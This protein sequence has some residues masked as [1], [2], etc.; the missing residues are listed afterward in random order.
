MNIFHNYLFLFIGSLKRKVV[1]ASILM[2]CLYAIVS[3]YHTVSGQ[4][5][6]YYNN[7]RNNLNL[8]VQRL[9][10]IGL[11]EDSRQQS[12]INLE[13][14]N[15]L[16]LKKELKGIAV[17]NNKNQLIDSKIFS[18]PSQMNTRFSFSEI[19]DSSFNYTTIDSFN[20]IQF[21]IRNGEFSIVLLAI[22]PPF[23]VQRDLVSEIEFKFYLFSFLLFSSIIVIISKFLENPIS[24]ITLLLNK[25][26]TSENQSE[27]IPENFL[28]K[29]EKNLIN[30][31]NKI[32]SFY[33]HTINN[34]K[35]HGHD[36]KYHSDD[37]SENLSTFSEA[38]IQQ[39]SATSQ[40]SAAFEELGS[41][42]N[43]IS[44]SSET[45]VSI[46]EKTKISAEEGVI[47]ADETYN[48]IIKIKTNNLTISDKLIELGNRSMMISKIMKDIQEINDQTQ[49]ISFNAMIEAVGAGNAGRRFKVVAEEIK[50]LSEDLER[51]SKSIKSTLNE[52][53]DFIQ[54]VIEANRE[55][56]PVIQR[57]LNSGERLSKK[58]IE[59]KDFVQQTNE[60]IKNIYYAI[61]Q[62]SKA[63][64][65]VVVSMREITGSAESFMDGSVKIM[66]ITERLQTISSEILA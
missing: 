52:I 45:I 47:I 39:G 24:K 8:E 12:K 6:I 5:D 57:S 27:T 59:I 35:K 26:S 63:V 10:V 32:N 58:L 28:D 43:I 16:S 37:L 19:L 9:S 17:Y 36:I 25:Y 61:E 11:D 23:I 29:S 66:S 15:D 30:E 41:S 20:L 51:R 42:I 55:I 56:D 64:N 60:N 44:K 53:T 22:K 14:F 62:Q 46:A 3:F 2:F 7:Y 50:I 21:P 4:T 13:T 33:F 54:N 31:I 18:F 40:T 1:T 65:E 34:L 48:S 49:L 38:I